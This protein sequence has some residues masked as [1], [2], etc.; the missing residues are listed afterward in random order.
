M[1]RLPPLNPLRA[2]EAAA[3]LS[4]GR[5]PPRNCAFRTAPS[6]S[7][8]ASLNIILVS[9]CFREAGP[10][11]GTDSRGLGL[12]GRRPRRTRSDLNIIR[13]V[14]RGAASP[15]SQSECDAFV[16]PSL[17]HSE[18]GRVPDRQSVDPATMSISTTDS[19][20]QLD[21]PYDFIFRRDAMV[22]EHTAA[23]AFSTM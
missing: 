7:R 3:R 18:D 14:S 10:P 21:A 4:S 5:P 20:D 16:R 23:A 13:T 11:R 2:F 17:A 9:G 22:R 12:S 8:F 19:I 1:R 15:F 6:A